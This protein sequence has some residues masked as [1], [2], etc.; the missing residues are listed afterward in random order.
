ME[1]YKQLLIIV[2]VFAVSYCG[3]YRAIIYGL[4]LYQLNWRDKR[5]KR[6]KEKLTFT[7]WL[8][9]SSFWIK[10]EIPK[11]LRIWNY[12][13]LFIHLGILAVCILFN[14]FT[15]PFAV[16]GSIAMVVFKFD[17]AWCAILTLFCQVKI[18]LKSHIIGLSQN[19]C[20]TIEIGNRPRQQDPERH[21]R[22]YL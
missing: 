21:F 12:L 2:G 13:L 14:F 17:F 7:E 3:L 9:Y 20:D 1:L 22:L 11:Y 16:D 5:F 10:R 19:I 6:E 15:V 8:F 18:D 4:L